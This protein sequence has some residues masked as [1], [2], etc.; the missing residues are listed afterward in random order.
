M[1]ALRAHYA[2]LG[3]DPTELNEVK[4]VVLGN[5]RI[6]KTQIVNRLRGA[7]YDDDA[8]STHGIALGRLA[9]PGCDGDF[10]VWD[11]GGQDIYHGTHA[12]FL[13]TN[14][15]ILL[16]WTP[17][18]D[19]SNET[20]VG[21]YTFRNRPLS[22]WIDFIRST[23]NQDAPVIVVQNQLD[24]HKD[25]GDH[26]AMGRLREH[27]DFVRAVAV[28]ARTEEGF[29]T[30]HD[31]IAAAVHAFNPPLIGRGRRA[32]IDQLAELRDEDAARDETDRQYRTLTFA[33]F[34]RRCEQVG[35]ISDVKQFLAFLHNAG[36]VFWREG[37]FED[38]VIL[39]QAWLLNAVYT[40]FDR[41]HCAN[42]LRQS[43]GRFGRATLGALVWDAAGYRRK[44]QALFISFMEAAGICFK[45][46][47]EGDEARYLAPD[48]LPD[49]SREHGLLGKFSG[50]ARAMTFKL[51]PPSLMRACISRVG[52]EARLNCHYWRHGF[53]GYDEKTRARLIVAQT[54]NDDWSGTLNIQTDGGDGQ[55]LL[56]NIESMIVDE[57]ARFGAAPEDDARTQHPDASPTPPRFGPDPDRA[58]QYFVSYAR[59]NAANPDL[60]DVVDE[61]CA[62]AKAEGLEIRRDENEI[63]YGDSIREFMQRLA[64]GD[65]VLICLSDKYLKSEFCMR[66]LLEIWRRHGS[67]ESRF[68]EHVWLFAL[69]DADIWTPLGRG[70]A[71]QYWAE[72]H[73]KLEPLIKHLGRKDLSKFKAMQEYWTLTGD[74]L[75]AIGDTLQPR[76]LDDLLEY[77][78]K[79]TGTQ[80]SDPG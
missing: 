8:D 11:F 6:G 20:Q 47:G 43:G 40:V 70:K 9:L 48:L 56:A 79:T 3:T 69:D 10:N 25:R 59:G 13:N 18:T 14:A 19:N 65:R 30:L 62:R 38:R 51:L 68:R 21:D 37:L 49:T 42:E 45:L 32:M 2:D 60:A 7:D 5:G 29:V 54:L 71:A 78:F 24:L 76:S 61:F 74:I 26:E 52:R 58:P 12:L 23:V 77:V 16:T 31:Y 55:S 39:D 4:L 27:H 80:A 44:E 57:A 63:N 17:D 22:W 64:K 50:P 73:A 46:S 34:E 28:S 67:D 75:E 15:V 53:C 66:E 41:A 72:Q 1:P 35:G 36:D 33:E